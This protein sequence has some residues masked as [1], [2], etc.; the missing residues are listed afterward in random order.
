MPL[1]NIIKQ[2]V[3][4]PLIALFILALAGCDNLNQPLNKNIQMRLDGGGSFL[5]SPKAVTDQVPKTQVQNLQNLHPVKMLGAKKSLDL[6]WKLPQVQHKAR[7][8]E[9]LSQ[10][11]I[12]V[13]STV[14]SVPQP[15][16]PYYI[17]RVYENHPDKSTNTIYWFRVSNPSG[18]IEPLDLINDKFIPLAKWNPDGI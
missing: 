9:E 4:C 15:N 3:Y 6:V 16:Q 18:M 11:S 8:I 14:D 1:I 10:G 7:E 5:K 13:T 17:V 12:Q 2:L